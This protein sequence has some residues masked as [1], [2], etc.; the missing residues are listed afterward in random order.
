MLARFSFNLTS[1]H[2]ST[3]P[4]FGRAGSALLRRPFC[5][6]RRRLPGGMLG[7]RPG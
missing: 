2:F 4:D 7:L 3:S 1:N 6:V 5:R